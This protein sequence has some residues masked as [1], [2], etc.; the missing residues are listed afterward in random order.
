MLYFFVAFSASLLTQPYTVNA[1]YVLII[2][3]AVASKRRM[4]RKTLA[5]ATD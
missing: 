5:L 4:Q 2:V 1:L 3:I